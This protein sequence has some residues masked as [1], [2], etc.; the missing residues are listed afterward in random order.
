MDRRQ[1][2][3]RNPRPRLDSPARSKERAA[4]Q[5]IVA[6]SPAFNLQGMSVRLWSSTIYRSVLRRSRFAS[7]ITCCTADRETRNSFAIAGGLRPAS[8][9]A[10]INRSCPAVTVAGLSGF[11]RAAVAGVRFGDRPATVELFG[12]L[13]PRR[14]PSSAT[15]SASRSSWASS[16]RRRDRHCPALPALLSRPACL[17]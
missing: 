4:A 5:V 6:K 17:R 11:A 8:K 7:V 12:A 16:S 1:A 2:D 13:R 3:G 14:R 15:A 10:R 9:A